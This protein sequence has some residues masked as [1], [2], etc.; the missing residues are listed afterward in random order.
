MQRAEGVI[1][2]PAVF[3]LGRPRVGVRRLPGFQCLRVVV[4]PGMRRIAGPTAFI[5]LFAA[6]ASLLETAPQPPSDPP[7]A[8]CVRRARDS[9][10]SRHRGVH[11]L[12]RRG[13]L[14]PAPP[15]YLHHIGTP[16][17]VPGIA[18]IYTRRH[19]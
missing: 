18:L 13:A 6:W 3:A 14:Q 4:L 12:W 11:S 19:V 16:H 15:L 10:A 1:L 5:W 17:G 9:V 2:R 7:V 8:G